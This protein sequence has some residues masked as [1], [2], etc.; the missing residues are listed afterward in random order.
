MQGLRRGE[1]D[2]QP[3]R[4]LQHNPEKTNM[5]IHLKVKKTRQW[6]AVQG[7]EKQVGEEPYSLL[8]VKTT[9]YSNA[10]HTLL[11][12]VRPK[13]IQEYRKQKTQ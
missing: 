4:Y 10:P 2:D 6:R 13:A 7:S 3:G 5:S 11:V 8:S 9:T 1:E 12:N